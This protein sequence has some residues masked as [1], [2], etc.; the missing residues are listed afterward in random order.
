MGD[1]PIAR[2]LPIHRTTQEH[3]VNTH[4]DTYALSGIR[5]HDPSVPA[6]EDSSYLRPR[7]HCDRRIYIYTTDVFTTIIT[8]V[9]PTTLQTVN[10]LTRAKKL[11]GRFESVLLNEQYRHLFFSPLCSHSP[12]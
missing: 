4:R 2:P 12:R 1:Q 6:S 3:R 8:A 7:D 10:S 11:S 9:M 5:A